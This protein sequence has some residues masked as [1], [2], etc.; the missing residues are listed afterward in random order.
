MNKKIR[1]Q[2]I[3]NMINDLRRYLGRYDIEIENSVI[4]CSP[5][6]M[7]GKTDPNYDR[8]KDFI[9][10]D[11]ILTQNFMLLN[12]R[13][14]LNNFLSRNFED[15]CDNV[16]TISA[17]I[18]VRYHNSS[19]YIVVMNSSMLLNIY[20]KSGVIYSDMSFLKNKFSEE[21]RND[22]SYNLLKFPYSEDFGW[23]FY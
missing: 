14:N 21:L 18:E 2:T 3:G 7:A 20:Y 12:I 13:K 10:T 15:F 6:A 5:L 8:H 16:T 19:D 9:K 1:V 17:A 22:K 11:N 23:Q 4:G